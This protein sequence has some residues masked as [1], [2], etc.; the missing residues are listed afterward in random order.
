MRGVVFCYQSL[1]SKDHDRHFLFLLLNSLNG[2]R[3]SFQNDFDFI[4]IFKANSFLLKA[5]D[6]STLFPA[7]ELL[8]CF[9]V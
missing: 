8:G 4:Y 5:K 1:L 6:V 3:V 7:N 2:Q 9:T